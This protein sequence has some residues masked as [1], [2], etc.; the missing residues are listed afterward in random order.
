MKTAYI[1]AALLAAGFLAGYVTAV[2]W[3]PT[4]FPNI[5]K[6]VAQQ[7]NVR[8]YTIIIQPA[9]IELA[10][11]V[12]WNAWTYNGTVPGP[13]LYAKVGDLIRI[14]AINKL[15][16][17]HSLHPHLPYYDLQHDGS[18]VNILTGVGKGSMIPPDGEWVYEWPATKAGIWYYHCHSADGGLR[19]VDHMLMGLYG[20]IIVD[21]VDEPPARNFVVFMAETPAVR[22]A[23][24]GTGQRPFYIMNGMGVPGGEPELEKIY[25]GK[26]T[27]FPQLRGLEGVAQ[28][29]NK[30]MPVFKAKLG[31]RLRFHI[32]NI[33]DLFH[34]FHAHVGDH[35][36][37]YVLGGRSWPAQVVPL[38]PG[39][40]DTVIPGLQQARRIPLPLPRRK[41]RR[42]WDDRAHNHR[43]VGWRPCAPLH[44]PSPLLWPRPL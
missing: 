4:F 39:A 28:L 27:I 19:I 16:L 43:R 13:T 38:V 15:N 30:S 31:E 35:K 7:G 6:A 10:P 3:A 26:S 5:F 1:I 18:Q 8:E 42:R 12:V 20:A 33:G 14:R 41:P 23:I 32:I 44:W 29:F 24:V 34:S 37:Q 25:V 17:T 9:Q 2:F 40:A 22:G 11:G 36:S 21:E